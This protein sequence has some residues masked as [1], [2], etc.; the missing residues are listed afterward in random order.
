MSFTVIPAIDLLDEQVV[1]LTQGDYNQKSVYHD[2]PPTLA[3]EMA[4]QGVKRLHVVDL[5]GARQGRPVQQALVQAMVK[6]AGIDIQI[7][8]GIRSLE[9]I[10]SYLDTSFPPRWI[11]LGTVALKQPQLVREACTRWPGQILVGIDA[12]DG[13]VAVEGW[14][15]ESQDSPLAVLRRLRDAGVSGAIYTDIARD[16][17]GDGPNI[18]STARIAIESGVPIIASGG[19]ATMAH[20][21]SLAEKRHC[22][23]SGVVVGRAI[24]SGALPLEQ[25]LEASYP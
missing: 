11:I 9:A 19:V 22:G 18:E 5:E 2:D 23:I 4:E 15:E 8:G 3:K 6:A 17:T 14:L 10:A 20:L 13:K 7:G 12:R 1:R 24:L 25:A 21:E 16:G